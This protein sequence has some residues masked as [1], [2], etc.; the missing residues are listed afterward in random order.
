MDSQVFAAGFSRWFGIDSLQGPKIPTGAVGAQAAFRASSRSIAGE[1]P[2][3]PPRGAGYSA[4]WNVP[5]NQWPFCLFT[6]TI[7]RPLRGGISDQ[8]ADF[9]SGN[10]GVGVGFR[11]FRSEEADASHG[12]RALRVFQVAGEKRSKPLLNIRAAMA[13]SSAHIREVRVFRECHSDAM[14]IVTAETFREIGARFFYGRGIRRPERA[15]LAPRGSCAQATSEKDQTNHSEPLMD[16]KRIVP[17]APENNSS[18]PHCYLRRNH[19]PLQLPSAYFN[20]SCKDGE[21]TARRKY[22]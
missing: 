7:I 3:G 1:L 10:D 16:G 17:S 20:R 14:R 12:V 11:Q 22:Y 4:S 19:T 2:A 6:M 18:E 13:V 21:V 15:G 9:R 8:S 5:I